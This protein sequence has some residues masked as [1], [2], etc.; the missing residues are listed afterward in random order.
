MKSPSRFPILLWLL[1]FAAACWGALAHAQTEELTQIRQRVASRAAE[2]A[3][4][5]SAGL[6]REGPGGQLVAVGQL[7]PQDLTTMRAENSDRSLAFSLIGMKNN[8]PS[9][10]VQTLFASGAQA[11]TPPSAP[12]HAPANGSPSPA[13]TPPA[14]PDSTSQ[15]TPP[16]TP[17]SAS[18]TTTPATPPAPAQTDSQPG[19]FSAAPQSSPV[20][21]A[22]QEALATKVLNRPAVNLYESPSESATRLRENL[23][24]FAVYY[25]LSSTPDWVQVSA[26]EGGPAL[27]W[28]RTQDTIPWRHNLAVRFAHEG[29]GNRQP[30]AFFE[31]MPRLET[32]LAQDAGTRLQLLESA[33]GRPNRDAATAAGIVAVQPALVDRNRFYILPIL[34]HRE[35]FPNQ[36]PALR[37]EA[38]LLRVAAMRQVESAAPVTPAGQT[39]TTQLQR[40]NL[41]IVF[42]MDL[43]SSMGPFVEGTKR[44]IDSL[45]QNLSS[46]ALASSVRFG[47]WGYR[48]TNPDQDFGGGKLTKNFTPVLQS[49][50]EFSNTLRGVK[51]SSSAAGDYAEAVFYGVRDALEKTAWTPGAMRVVILIGDASS[52]PPGHAKNPDNLS[53][54]TLRALANAGTT[55]TYVL[56]IYILRDSPLAPA[57]AEVA[58]PQFRTLGRNPNVAGEGVFLEI[59][60]QD[61]A[62]AFEQEIRAA[63]E[64]FVTRLEGASDF[65]ARRRA[66]VAATPTPSSHQTTS[67]VTAADSIFSGA[68]LDWLAAQPQEGSQVEDSLTGWALDKD[69]A[70]PEIQAL[71]VVFLITK[72]QLDTLVRLLNQIIDAGVRSRVRGTQFFSSLQSVVGR[73][74]V[75]PNALS[76][77][78]PL[79]D[80]RLIPEFLRVLPYKSDL[81]TLTADEWRGMTAVE[82]TTFLDRLNSNINFYLD[83]SR[84]PAKW[85]ALNPEDHREAHVAAIPLDRLP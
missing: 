77:N 73:A 39:S 57:D 18:P 70:A 29:R 61:N 1:V 27:G 25:V 47:F 59:A 54:G 49:R 31:S 6:I 72:S 82:Q 30:V 81:L 24:G 55:P 48:D 42:L 14:A 37:G 15:A 3:R 60:Q 5:K 44:A 21:S 45:A 8:L 28:L 79:A 19:H 46:G 43:S 64:H 10:Q 53:E 16:A 65:E 40:P 12:P 85:H 38:R 84:D 4:M 78:T 71:D 41:D 67:A 66:P 9:T 58:R 68:Y 32:A 36:F 83:L 7:N 34:E 76:A 51:V 35:V 63:L 23:P 74:A 75:D 26:T 62:A 52:H 2:I 50:E 33:A 80:T 20:S 17:P 69:L 13:S 11:A 56:P 22:G